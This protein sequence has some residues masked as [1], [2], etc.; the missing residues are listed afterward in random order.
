VLLSVPIALK[1]GQIMESMELV[2]ARVELIG[3]QQSNTVLLVTLF[4]QLF[5]ELLTLVVNTTGIHHLQV[6]WNA[7]A[8]VLL[9]PP[10][11]F[12]LN[13]NVLANISGK[14]IYVSNQLARRLNFP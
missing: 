6:A 12:R 7:E 10:Q 13:V 3:M 1:L 5:V 2:T 4:R 8:I 9:E 11:L 14:I